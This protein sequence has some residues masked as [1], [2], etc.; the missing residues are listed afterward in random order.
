MYNESLMIVVNYLFYFT[1][2]ATGYYSESDDDDDKSSTAGDNTSLSEH[3][4]LAS[5][6]VNKENS[7]VEFR[8]KPRGPHG[9]YFTV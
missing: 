5:P 2:L 3:W 9:K 7:P 8:H 4:M 1:Y 6:E